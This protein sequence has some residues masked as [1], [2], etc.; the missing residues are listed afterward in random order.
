MYRERAASHRVVRWV[1][2]AATGSRPD[3][4]GKAITINEEPVTVVGVLPADFDFSST[5]RQARA[6]TRSRRS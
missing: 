3:I 4:V 2:A 6:S 5:S 1:L